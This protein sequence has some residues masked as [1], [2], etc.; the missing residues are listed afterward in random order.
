MNKDLSQIEFYFPEGDFSCK[1]AIA[2]A[3]VDAVETNNSLGHCGY[4]SKK[5]LHESMMSHMGHGSTDYS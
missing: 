4:L 5:D 3:V 1:E 2:D